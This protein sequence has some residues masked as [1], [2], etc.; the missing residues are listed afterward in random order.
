M[1]PAEFQVASA[2][3]GGSSSGDGGGQSTVSFHAS[4]KH[5]FPCQYKYKILPAMLCRG[6][7]QLQVNWTVQAVCLM[8][9]QMMVSAT[10]LVT[11]CCDVVLT[12]TF[13]YVHLTTSTAGSDL[14]YYKFA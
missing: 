10:E 4:L 13:D 3:G 12:L 2:G 11:S 14:T 8:F 7:C 1:F 5:R 6:H 9:F